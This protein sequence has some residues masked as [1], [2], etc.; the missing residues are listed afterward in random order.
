VYVL[1]LLPEG[2]K[3]IYDDSFPVLGAYPDAC[4]FYNASRFEVCDYLH[5]LHW[6]AYVHTSIHCLQHANTE[7]VQAPIG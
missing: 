4:M 3:A 7:C 6:C 2:F 5:T 1:Q